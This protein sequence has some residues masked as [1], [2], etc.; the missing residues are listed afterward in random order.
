MSNDIM[1]LECAPV[2][3]STLKNDDFPTFGRP[4]TEL[5]T[6]TAQTGVENKPT[7][8]ILR[9]LPGLPRRIFFS[10][11]TAFFGGILF[12]MLSRAVDENGL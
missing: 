9:L 8:P 1:D 4:T 2:S 3:E 10:W 11:A 6:N 7:I 5:S 12:L